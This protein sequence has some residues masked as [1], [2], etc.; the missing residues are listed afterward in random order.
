MK[1]Y[2][3][4]RKNLIVKELI[5]DN[6]LFKTAQNVCNLYMST[7]NKMEKSFLN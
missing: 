2:W 1:I 7:I 5:L 4:D 6:I 3:P